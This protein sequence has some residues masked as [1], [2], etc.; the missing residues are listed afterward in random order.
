MGTGTGWGQGWDGDGRGA[1]TGAGG[2]FST[3]AGQQEPGTRLGRTSSGGGII[4]PGWSWMLPQ[5]CCRPVQLPKPPRLVGDLLPPPP[6]RCRGHRA[7]LSTDRSC[8]S[9][10]SR[11]TAAPREPDPGALLAPSTA[12]G[13]RYRAAAAV[14]P[15]G[16]SCLNPEQPL[17]L[18]GSRMVL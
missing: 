8:R 18:R 2:D 6:E 7:G 16:R 11:D 1:P 14:P 12:P 17:V 4:T 5:P 3:P 9:P 13:L 10:S 15:P